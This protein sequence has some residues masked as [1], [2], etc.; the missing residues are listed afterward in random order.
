MNNDGNS[1]EQEERCIVKTTI[2]VK[3]D[4]GLGCEMPDAGT[5][6]RRQFLRYSGMLAIGGACW[7]PLG[8]VKE[9]LAE[10]GSYAESAKALSDLEQLT[11]QV[12]NVLSASVRVLKQ[13]SIAPTVQTKVLGQLRSRGPIAHVPGYWVAAVNMAEVYRDQVVNPAMND[14]LGSDVSS[15]GEFQN[16]LTRATGPGLSPE[17]TPMLPAMV[18]IVFIPDVVAADIFD[19]NSFGDIADGMI[20]FP[21]AGS[22]GADWGVVA[23]SVAGVVGAVVGALIGGSLGAAIGT[24]VANLLVALWDWLTSDDNGDDGDDKPDGDE[25]D[26]GDNGDQL[27]PHG[28][29]GA[30]EGP[31][32]CASPG[33]EAVAEGLDYVLGTVHGGIIASVKEDQSVVMPQTDAAP[34]MT[35][36]MGTETQETATRGISWGQIK[37]QER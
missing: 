29:I 30:C 27:D 14:S 22:G 37:L 35:L 16:F 36:M 26:G 10:E 4:S 18:G 12:R 2:S 33:F 23:S 7:S 31:V 13:D 11:P 28:I 24:A 32:L 21:G 3:Q 25:P 17:L 19:P 9:L 6:D 8:G 20:S 5:V 15:L 34:R 1:I